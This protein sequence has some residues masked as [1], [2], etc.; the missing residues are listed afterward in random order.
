MDPVEKALWFIESHF[1]NEFSVDEV[2]YVAGV[3]RFHLSRL[4]ALALGQ[5][6]TCYARARRLSQAARA[7]AAGAPDILAVALAHGYGSH[8]AFTRAFRDQFGATPEQVRARRSL[9]N[10]ALQEP[11]RMHA[12][13]SIDLA[14]PRLEDAPILLITGLGA[15]YTRGGDPAIPSQW[16]HFAPHLGHISEQVGEIAYGVWTNFDEDGSFEYITGAEVSRFA[17]LPKGFVTLRVPAR[18]YAVFTHKAHISAIPA[19]CQAIW[20]KWA[21]ETGHKIADAPSFERYDARFDPAT[22]RGEVEI[23]IPLES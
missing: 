20:A 18:R 7:L 1:E 12:K 16:Q 5:S 15:R 13:T 14:S 17:D 8:E 23:W 2:A 19:T 4:F 22:G 11:L 9:E 3:S 10:L 21:P 6:V